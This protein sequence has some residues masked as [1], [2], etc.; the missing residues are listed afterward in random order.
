MRKPTFCISETKY[1][2][3]LCCNCKLI[4]AFVFALR[5][6]QFLLF[7]NPKF[8]GSSH[9]LCL[10]SLV[11]VKPIRKPQCWFSYE[12]AHIAFKKLRSFWLCEKMCESMIQV[13][14]KDL[15]I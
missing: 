1:P 4:S 12:A 10:N 11:C 6:V 2:D 5:I 13:L 14:I 3:Q 7:L 15:L 8:P 9:L